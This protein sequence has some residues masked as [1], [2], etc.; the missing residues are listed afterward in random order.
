MINIKQI[1]CKQ[2]LIKNDILMQESIDNKAKIEEQQKAVEE[3][4]IQLKQSNTFINSFH[5]NN[6]IEEYWNN[7]RPKRLVTWEARNNYRMDVRS[8]FQVDDTLPKFTGSNDEIV[9]DVL[10][11]CIT[12]IKYIP[13]KEENWKYAYETLKLKTGDCEDGAILIANILVNSGV[14][15]WKIR[16]NKGFVKY[17]NQKTYH[18]FLTYLAEKDNVWYMIDWCYFPN[19]SRDLKLSWKNAE[20]YFE[21]DASWNSKF[22]FSGLNKE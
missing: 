8:F 10:A 3:L 22:A 13:D 11:W 18:C 12:N 9:S 7:K 1:F 14:S 4:Q 20:K 19:E 16:L 17:N 6:Q 5:N 21:P 15:Y 2:E